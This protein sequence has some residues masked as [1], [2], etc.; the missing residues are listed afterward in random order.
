MSASAT[1][2]SSTWRWRRSVLVTQPSAGL[3]PGTFG[4]VN[5]NYVSEGASSI[6]KTNKYSLKIDHTLSNTQSRGV[7]VQ[8]DEEQH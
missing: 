5:N 8:P 2:P 7:R 4:Y 1:S 6:E 3:V